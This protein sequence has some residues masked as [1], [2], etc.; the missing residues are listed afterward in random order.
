MQSR[1]LRGGGAQC[2]PGEHTKNELFGRRKHVHGEGH[3][4]LIYLQAHPAHKG[5]QDPEERHGG[6]V[7]GC[8]RI[9]RKGDR[10]RARR[11]SK[12]V[13]KRRKARNTRV[14]RGGISSCPGKSLRVLSQSPTEV[15]VIGPGALGKGGGKVVGRRR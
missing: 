7:A 15:E 11:R 5:V 13:K 6:R 2:Q 4:I 1:N 3:L 10:R 12:K 8:E 9:E 14:M